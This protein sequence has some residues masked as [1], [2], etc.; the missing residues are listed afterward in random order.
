M[1]LGVIPA[2]GG[3]KGV[4]NKN[5]RKI[6][7]KPLIAWSIESAFKSKL[8]DDF[9][10]STE[11]KKIAE[12]AQY[13]GAKILQRPD[14]L[15]TDEATTLSVLQ[16]I[17]EEAPADIIVVLQPTSP[18]RDDDLVD[19]CIAQ[20]KEKKSDCLGTGF[21]YAIKVYG[22]NNNTPRQAMKCEFVEDGNVYVMKKE[23]IKTGKWTGG[24]I[25]YFE[26]GGDQS[27]QIDT[28]LDFFILRN[29]LEKRSKEKINEIIKPIRLLAIDVDGVLTDAGMYYSQAGDE[30]KKFN[31]RDG[32]GIELLRKAGVKIALITKEK[33][34]IVQRRAE[35]LKVD[36]VYQGIEN[37]IGALK[38]IVDKMD[39]D[40]DKV[41]FIGDDV[42]D[43][44]ALSQVGFSATPE[45]G[46]AENKKIVNYV[47]TKSGG[48]GCVREVCDLILSS[49]QKA[50]NEG[51]RVADEL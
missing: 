11:D 27:Y 23:L 13:Y 19:R 39:M 26:L 12:I 35:K 33:S 43:T 17:I 50:K 34:K 51:E 21:N 1:I 49:I 4:P 16:H 36:F 42:N 9:I 14:H 29:L 48:D 37:K 15:A 40:L 46:M 41:A 22:A 8:L 45:D 32:M 20:F 10:V 3:S 6:A 7:G 38:E 24:K 5:I 2:R 30:L 47:C 25:E 44:Q 31:T 28:E 18:I